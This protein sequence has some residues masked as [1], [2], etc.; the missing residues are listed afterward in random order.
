VNKAKDEGILNLPVNVGYSSDFPILQYAD[1]TLLIM[2]VCPR[3][4]FAL[5]AIL[6]TFDS[7]TGLKVN[8]SKSLMVPINVN[9]ERLQHL[10]TTF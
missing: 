5:K 7:S 6:N 1:D 8:Y 10:S 2:E 4:L 9:P 3:Q